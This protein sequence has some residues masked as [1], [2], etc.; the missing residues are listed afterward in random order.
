METLRVKQ[1]KDAFSELFCT[2]ATDGRDCLWWRIV[3]FR[4]L[5]SEG[6]EENEPSI[7]QSQAMNHWLSS[8]DA[9]LTFQKF[10]KLD[11]SSIDETSILT[12][13]QLDAIITDAVN[14]LAKSIA[15]MEQT[16]HSKNENPEVPRHVLEYENI[17][18]D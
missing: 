7:N 14:N 1:M 11:V 17:K 6:Q 13:V 3:S 5:Y 15:N 4:E 18:K 2:T 8:E 16:H 12:L 9:R 10:W